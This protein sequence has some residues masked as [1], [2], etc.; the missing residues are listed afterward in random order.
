[1]DAQVL[2]L[3]TGPTP[4]QKAYPP[5]T[6]AFDASIWEFENCWAQSSHEI[7]YPE[8]ADPIEVAKELLIKYRKK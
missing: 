5:P 8:P 7:T 3:S 1:M 4:D 2:T 6:K